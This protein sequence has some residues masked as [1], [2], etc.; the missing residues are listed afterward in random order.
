[1]HTVVL[2]D[3]LM[4][5]IGEDGFHICD[6]SAHR[7]LLVAGLLSCKMID[8]EPYDNAWWAKVGGVSVKHLNELEIYTVCALGHKLYVSSSDMSAASEALLALSP[9]I[10]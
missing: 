9:G 7:V 3:R 4:Q 6:A 10:V 8:D 1:M 5:L 2:I